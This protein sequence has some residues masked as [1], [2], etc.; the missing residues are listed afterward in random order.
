MY[1]DSG[2]ERSS[3]G[4]LSF[5]RNRDSIRLLLAFQPNQQPIND[6]LDERHVPLK[7]RWRSV[8][9]KAIFQVDP[10]VRR[11]RIQIPV[12][13]VSHK[14]TLSINTEED[15]QKRTHERSIPRLINAVTVPLNFVPTSTYTSL[16][17]SSLA[18]PILHLLSISCSCFV[19][20]RRAATVSWTFDPIYIHSNGQI[21][22][23]FFS[24]SRKQFHAFDVR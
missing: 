22:N 19:V 11:N 5:F 7:D 21:G 6:L 16:T 24:F 2:G 15:Q 1:I 18:F 10:K 9:T 14:Q 12:K 23:V 3:P 20:S 17:C 4:S 8:F 13:Y